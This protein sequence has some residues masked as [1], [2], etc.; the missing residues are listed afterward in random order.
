MLLLKKEYYIKKKHKKISPI[1]TKAEITVLSILELHFLGWGGAGLGVCVRTCPR[2]SK[3]SGNCIGKIVYW[4]YSSC[5][6]S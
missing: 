2:K 3:H 5:S 1:L 4:F 6:P